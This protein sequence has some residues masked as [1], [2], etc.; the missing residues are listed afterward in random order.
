MR[1]RILSAALLCT[2]GLR[3]AAAT[4]DASPAGSS[5]QAAAIWLA[6][7]LHRPVEPAQIL[8]APQAGPLEGCAITRMRPAP[9]GATSLS[10]RCPAHVLPQLVL[11]KIPFDAIADAKDAPTAVSGLS[12]RS[13]ATRL[14][15]ALP[16]G[17]AAVV[18]PKAPPLVRAGAALEADWRTPALHAE[19]PVVALDSGAAGAEIRVR[20][21]QGSRVLRARILTAHTVTI[22]AAG[23]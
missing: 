1:I 12:S 19:L 20:I 6:Q 13:S 2:L 7:Q 10:L 3:A 21:A 23:A 17:A 16:V 9:T 15:N 22:V 4:A 18:L 14:R 8:V 5:R 11:L